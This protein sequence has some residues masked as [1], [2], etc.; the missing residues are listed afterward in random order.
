MIGN[1]SELKTH[2][3]EN[4]IEAAQLVGSHRQPVAW[5]LAAEVTILGLLLIDLAI[6]STVPALAMLVLLAGFLRYANSVWLTAFLTLVLGARFF[7]TGSQQAF[8]IRSDLL[9]D[10]VLILLTLIASF[11]HIELR[12]YS[13]A[14]ELG[15]SYRRLNTTSKPSLVS[16]VNTVMGQLIRRQWYH[17]LLAILAAYL[18]LWNIP[19]TK[20]WTQKYWL[21]PVGGRFIFLSLALFLGWFI[22]RAVF[23]MWDWFCLTPQQ[24]DVAMRSWTNREF[25]SETAGIQRRQSN[26]RKADNDNG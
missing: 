25:W 14:F 16:V 3:N 1:K 6:P 7:Q 10:C 4:F 24:A 18:L 12:N 20:Q 23:S 11:R 8:L 19:A 17:S 15:K 21:D 26:L 2:S 9:L 13:R 22:C 5:L